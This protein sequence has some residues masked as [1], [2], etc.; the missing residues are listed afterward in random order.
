M[1]IVRYELRYSE[2]RE[3]ILVKER[4]FEFS[5]NDDS[6]ISSPDIAVNVVTSI[7]DVEHLTEEYVWVLAVD[8]V[9]RP[10]G[11]FEVSHGASNS[12]CV[13]NREIFVRLCVCGANGFL[14]FHNHPGGSL[15]PS[16]DDKNLTKTVKEAGSLMGIG[17]LDHIILSDNT[18]YFSFKEAG[19]L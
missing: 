15:K 9:N 17:L 6:H 2:E 4:E 8:N 12:C 7:F 14:L 1:K 3:T 18:N 5:H 10:I 16:T 11:I 13:R 19:M